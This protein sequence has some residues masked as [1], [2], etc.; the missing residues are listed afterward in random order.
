MADEALAGGDCVRA[1]AA[2][3]RRLGVGAA[4]GDDTEGD[5]TNSEVLTDSESGAYTISREAAH[6]RGAAEGHLLDEGDANFLKR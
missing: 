5:D 4:V 3:H 6:A 1:Q 2:H